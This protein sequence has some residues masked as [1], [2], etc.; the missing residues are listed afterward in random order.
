MVGDESSCHTSQAACSSCLRL[1]VGKE[2]RLNL[3]VIQSC[4]TVYFWHMGH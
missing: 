2:A 1:Q 4:F 3:W